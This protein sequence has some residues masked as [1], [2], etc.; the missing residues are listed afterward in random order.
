MESFFAILQCSVL[1][2][3]HL[4]E[5]HE[6]FLA[7]ELATLINSQQDKKKEVEDIEAKLLVCRREIYA[8]FKM[9]GDLV[10]TE[11]ASP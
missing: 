1:E 3:F 6:S 10:N 8:C 5:K 9:I 2:T 7:L 11:Y 4:L